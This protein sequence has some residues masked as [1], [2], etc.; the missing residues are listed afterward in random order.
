MS[1]NLSWVADQTT[2]LLEAT[3]ELLWA[4]R[5][6]V[7]NGKVASGQARVYVALV[8]SACESLPVSEKDLTR[9][10]AACE[11]TN[12][13]IAVAVEREDQGLLAS[14]AGKRPAVESWRG[15]GSPK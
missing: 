1:D 13:A 9:L 15:K 14:T 3:V 4:H 10:S 8:K 2:K 11:A 5:N 7:I 12:L 6:D